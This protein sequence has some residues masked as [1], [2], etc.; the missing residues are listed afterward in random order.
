MALSISKMGGVVH[1]AHHG[2]RRTDEYVLA[3][4]RYVEPNA[5]QVKLV[6][7]AKINWL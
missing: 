5:P 7:E 6:R 2:I 4:M 3:G 1:M